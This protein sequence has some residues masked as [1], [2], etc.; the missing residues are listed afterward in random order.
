MRRS[1]TISALCLAIIS[2][3]NS[4]PAF[5]D[6][7]KVWNYSDEFLSSQVTISQKGNA[8]DLSGDKLIPGD[9]SVTIYISNLK[10]KFFGIVDANQN[11]KKYNSIFS[12]NSS[13]IKVN[14]F[15]DQ[16]ATFVATVFVM[17]S[18]NPNFPARGSSTYYQAAVSLAM[19]ES[20][21][22]MRSH[23]K[24]KVL[25]QDINDQGPVETG[26]NTFRSPRYPTG[27]FLELPE[28]SLGSTGALYIM[29][30]TELYENW[31]YFRTQGTTALSYK[32][33]QT[34]IEVSKLSQEIK[35]APVI[36]VPFKN[37]SARI[38]FSSTSDLPVFAVENDSSICLVDK[39]IVHFLKSGNCSITLSQS[40]NEIYE[41]APEKRF[42]LAILPNQTGSTITCVKDKLTK[43]VTAI[44]PKCP[45]GYKV[46]K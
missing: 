3:I 2:A 7:S 11:V 16:G 5:A 42:T 35:V 8:A 41:K 43:K 36:P 25:T 23:Y 38:S 20:G 18:D 15:T 1:I 28:F 34:S 30:W 6:P 45:A 27:Y 9:A 40:G 4:P 29:T 17:I 46:K 33:T 26:I 19:D 24:T 39:D 37:K 32:N 22:V 10:P 31:I 12:P 13:Y 14:P 21:N 44:K